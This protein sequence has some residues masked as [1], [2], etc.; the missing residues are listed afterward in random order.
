MV[1]TAEIWKDIEGY[2]GLYQVSNLGRV[3][4]LDKPMVVYGFQKIPINTIRKGKVLSPRLSQDGYEKVS[5]T[6]DKKPNNLFV[7]RLVAK[8]FI[9]NDD[10]CKE[11]NHIDGNKRNNEVSNLEWCTHLENMQHCF[12]NSLRKKQTKPMLGRTYSKSPY[13]KKVYQYDKNGNLMK[14]WSSIREASE[15]HHVDGSNISRCCNGH[16]KSCKG[17]VWSFELKE[18]KMYRGR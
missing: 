1:E 16:A 13:A 12:K 7:H 4:S 8:A 6:K 5:L 3:R 10:D 11:V 14:I 9:S 17:F 2:E 18:L 15:Y